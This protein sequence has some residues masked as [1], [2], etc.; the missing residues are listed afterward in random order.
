MGSITSKETVL[1]TI[2]E[3][4]NNAGDVLQQV[5]S[6]GFVKECNGRSHF[7]ITDLLGIRNNKAS[8]Y[9]NIHL[10]DSSYKVK[11]QAFS[12]LKLFFSFIDLFSLNKSF[13]RG[14][15]DQEVK[16]LK[17]FIKG[18]IRKGTIWDMDINTTRSNKTISIYLGIYRDF[19]KN[20]L[21]ITDSS[22]HKKST[23]QITNG[24]GF[25]GHTEKKVIERYDS[26]PRTKRINKAP[27]Y[28]K[29]SEYEKIVTL[30]NNKY[31]LR[32]HIIVK[33]MYEY[34]LRIGEVLGL[35]LEDINP[36]EDDQIFSLTLRNRVSD[37]SWQH[38][39][40]LLIPQYIHQ[41]SENE[42]LTKKIGYGIVYIHYEMKEMLEEYIEEIIWDERLLSKSKKKKENLFFKSKSDSIT[43]EENLFNKDNYYIFLSHLQYLPLTQGGWNKLL[44]NIFEES[45]LKLDVTTKK[46]NLSHRFRH[47]F[48]MNKVKEGLTEIELAEALR[49]SGTH[50]VKTYYN[51]DE[52]DYILLLKKQ[53]ESWNT[54]V[55]P[56]TKSS[57]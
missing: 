54:N 28:I 23:L 34:G 39:K 4:R 21:N 6:I 25:L 53:K 3:K 51:P 35:T 14:F 40:N 37:K 2:Y 9:L 29:L 24:D 11:E 45:G 49:H 13:V 43:N 18:G 32:D 8:H 17:Q 1:G 56:T 22:L 41:Y 57:K 50:S 52:E 27:K 20:T 47:G 42:Y 44:R 5:G 12:A 38:C 26:N 31:T 55:P 16:S 33:L 46:D 7:V 10:C 48:A 19:Y 36:T 15:N 30:I